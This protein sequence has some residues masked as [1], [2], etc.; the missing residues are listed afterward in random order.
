MGVEVN[1]CSSGGITPTPLGIGYH[2]TGPCTDIVEYP[3]SMQTFVLSSSIH[4]GMKVDNSVHVPSNEGLDI[5]A[6]VALSYTLDARKA[7]A[8]YEKF[9]MDLDR[10]EGTF[11]RNMIREAMRQEFGKYTAEQLYAGKQA[12]VRLEVEKFLHEKLGAEGFQVQNFSINRTQMPESV[13]HS[14]EAKVAMTQQAQQAENEVR[15]TQALATQAVA[16]AE[17]E[18]KVA[19]VR[20][21]GLADAKRLQAD[22]EAYYIERTT[23]ALTPAFVDYTRAQ[24]WN[25]VLPQVT[26]GNTPII[27]LR[28]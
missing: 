22:S 7:P 23:R 21:Q 6:D 1:R 17:G 14:I 25:G 11:M 26:S 27:D 13:I 2:T 12:E 10:I 16:T 24:K 5:S 9:K 19:K 18:A 15:K 4:D 28:K 20:A 8:I 3:V